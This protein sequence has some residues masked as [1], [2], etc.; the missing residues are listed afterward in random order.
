M[1]DACASVP[2]PGIVIVFVMCET[3]LKMICFFGA[4]RDE[5]LRPANLF[6][7]LRLL[8]NLPRP[9]PRLDPPLLRRNLL[10]LLLKGRLKV[11]LNR[12]LKR[13]GIV[14]SIVSDCIVFS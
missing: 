13:L 10:V 12:L 9:S 5:I 8:L 7:P 14:Y 4:G 11:R 6:L 3:Y 2:P 1:C